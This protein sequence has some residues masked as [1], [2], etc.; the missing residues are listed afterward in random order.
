M[1]RKYADRLDW[2]RVLRRT[3]ACEYIEEAE[4]SGHISLISIDQVSS[5]IIIR[6][7]DENLCLANDGYYWMQHFPEGSNYC[8]TTML[9]E[10]KEIIQ[11]YF[12]ISKSIGLNEEG[13]PYWDDLY[14]DIVVLPNGD[15]YIKDVDELEDA[16]NEKKIDEDD[17]LLAKNTLDGLLQEITSDENHIMRNS[18]KHFEYLLTSN[19]EGE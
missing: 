17:F 13:V 7:G 3:Y 12:D 18:M 16:L 14:I 1:K 6:I 4:F 11:W 5:P 15:F 10:N 9:N 8:V 19:I 2:Y